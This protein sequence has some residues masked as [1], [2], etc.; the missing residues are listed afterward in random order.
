VLLL[1]PPSEGKTAA[2]S[3]GPVDLDAL[4]FPA[5]RPVREARIAALEQLASGDEERAL[6]ELKLGPRSRAD[7]RD[8]LVLRVAPAAPAA[9]VYTGVLFERLGLATLPSD[10]RRRAADRLLIASALWGVLR[11]DDR[12]PSYRCP[13][14]ARLPGQPTAK[15]A[16]RPAL[17]AVLPRDELVVD[18]RSGVYRDLWAGPA[19]GHVVRVGVVRDTG[20]KRIVVSHD[21]KATRGAVARALLC[22][23]GAWAGPATPEG[24]AHRLAAAG[25]EIEL[26][27]GGGSRV[28]ELTVVDRG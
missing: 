8:D 10:A 6:K 22:D 23:P 24:V 4:A 18:L 21:A 7:L 15:R 28:S 12:I 14:T 16:W 3:G 5:L 13:A 2:T 9:E 17:D 27:D 26:A 11:P 1:A 20:A 25:W 19:E